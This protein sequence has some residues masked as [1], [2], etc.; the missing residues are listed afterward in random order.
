MKERPAGEDW[1]P[2]IRPYVPDL[3]VFYCPV[4]ARAP[5]ARITRL[6]IGGWDKPTGGGNYR[7]GFALMA[8]LYAQ[9]GHTFH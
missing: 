7:I 1:R 2:I 3:D 9:S 4:S 6:G 8:G 5:S